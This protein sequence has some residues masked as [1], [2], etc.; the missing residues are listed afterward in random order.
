MF[1]G[2]FGVYCL[3]FDCVVMFDTLLTHFSISLFLLNK[4]RGCRMLSISNQVL[5][6]YSD[7]SCGH[8]TEG[9][10]YNGRTSFILGAIV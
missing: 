6:F 1:Q 8:V 4:F 9:P 7:S 5:R 2:L 10:T 3:H